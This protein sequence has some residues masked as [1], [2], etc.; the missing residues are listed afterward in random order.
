MSANRAALSLA[1]APKIAKIVIVREPAIVCVRSF[2]ERRAAGPAS[3]ALC[4]EPHCPVRRRAA[5]VQ[6]LRL[7]THVAPKVVHALIEFAYDHERTVVP[8]R[9]PSLIGLAGDEVSGHVE[10]RSHVRDERQLAV[11]VRI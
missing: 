4:R 3:D 6:F 8:E 1:I 5:W 9:L 10:R 11:F 2:D 7:V